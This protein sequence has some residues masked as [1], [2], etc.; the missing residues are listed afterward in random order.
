MRY[1]RPGDMAL[2]GV[3]FRHL[4]DLPTCSILILVTF[5]GAR[6]SGDALFKVNDPSTKSGHICKVHHKTWN[7]VSK[8]DKRT[9]KRRQQS[10]VETG[11]M[12]LWKEFRIYTAFRYITWRDSLKQPAV[13][14]N[15][16][17]QIQAMEKSEFSISNSSRTKSPSVYRTRTWFP[18]VPSWWSPSPIVRFEVSLLRVLRYYDPIVMTL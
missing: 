18:C 7:Q 17:I 8:T 13:V 10:S 15:M 5:S 9:P 3:L 11:D 2:E 16:K 4:R 12:R 1:A 6:K 14:V